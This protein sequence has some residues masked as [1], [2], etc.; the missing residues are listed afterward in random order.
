MST[1][2]QVETYQATAPPPPYTLS[3]ELSE[4]QDWTQHHVDDGGDQIMADELD[5]KD[6]SYSQSSTGSVDSNTESI[7]HLERK[8]RGA[9][10][11]LMEICG[12]QKRIRFTMDKE[13]G[14]YAVDTQTRMNQ[15]LTAAFSSVLKTVSKQESDHGKIWSQFL[16]KKAM[17]NRFHINRGQRP[18]FVPS[19]IV[20]VIKAWRDT[21]LYR[22]VKFTYYFWAI[23]T[24]GLRGQYQSPPQHSALQI[25]KWLKTQQISCFFPITV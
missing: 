24:L 15:V 10:N 11:Y 13:F 4:P 7:F 14:S 19:L 5:A 16:N 3:Q 25:S 1:N 8:R 22:Y 6:T 9:M 23:G 17:F 21:Q 20:S 18:G 12:E 2:L